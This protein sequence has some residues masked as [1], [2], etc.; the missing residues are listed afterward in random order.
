M[1]LRRAVCWLFG[2]IV[3]Y[4][5]NVAGGESAV[6]SWSADLV[7]SDLCVVNKL[8]K[9]FFRLLYC[10]SPFHASHLVSPCFVLDYSIYLFIIII[11]YFAKDFTNEKT[12][13]LGVRFVQVDT[14][15]VFCYKV[16]IKC[17]FCALVRY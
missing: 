15:P 13:I 11:K 14:F 10:G 5:K 4:D 9:A 3:F 8:E 17:H 6:R 2:S 1:T 16:A 7:V 12:P